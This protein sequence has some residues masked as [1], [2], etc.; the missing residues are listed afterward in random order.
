MWLV[1]VVAW[2]IV[3]LFP[4]P[5]GWDALALGGMIPAAL[6][7]WV[8]YAVIGLAAIWVLMYAYDP[9]PPADDDEIAGDLPR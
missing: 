1:L 3:G 4:G 8:V 5:R 9:Y 7:Y 6:L 2:L